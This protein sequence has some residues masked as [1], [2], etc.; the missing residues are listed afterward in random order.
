[1]AA[2]IAPNDVDEQRRLITL[3]VAK[4]IPVV[5]KIEAD[6]IGRLDNT[7]DQL[8]GCRMTDFTF[9]ANNTEGTLMEEMIVVQ[10]LPWAV[11]IYEG[12][13][14]E[15]PADKKVADR[16]DPNMERWGF[17]RTHYLLLPLWYKVAEEVA[18]VM[19]SSASIE[20][21]FSLLNCMV[22]DQQESALKDYKEASVRL[23]YNENFRKNTIN[24][25]SFSYH[26]HNGSILI[27]FVISLSLLVVQRC[28]FD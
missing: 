13:R 16:C 12:L 25:L 18:L 17:W 23:R 9:V 26:Y 15:F 8:K 22:D 19:V 14:M 11:P 20:R 5:E 3:T 10:Y 21:V 4:A 7:L 6:T 2:I 27:I 1:M 28:Y 24:N